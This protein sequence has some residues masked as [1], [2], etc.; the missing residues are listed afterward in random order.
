M[1]DFFQTSKTKMRCRKIQ[2][3]YGTV[4]GKAQSIAEQIHNELVSKKFE[5]CLCIINST[6]NPKV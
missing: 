3:A 1:I 6:D 5:V 2:C 4:T